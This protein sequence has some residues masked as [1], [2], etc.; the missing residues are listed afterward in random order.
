[1]AEGGNLL[2]ERSSCCGC[3]CWLPLQEHL[4]RCMYRLKLGYQFK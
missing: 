2:Q 3:C 4:A 1:L